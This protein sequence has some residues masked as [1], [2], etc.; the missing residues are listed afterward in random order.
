MRR[1][2]NVSDLGRW[3]VAV[4]H[5]ALPS[6]SCEPVVSRE[7]RSYEEGGFPKWNCRAHRQLG[8]MAAALS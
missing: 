2:S 5:A 3:R 4:D 1:A 7:V 8:W 6:D